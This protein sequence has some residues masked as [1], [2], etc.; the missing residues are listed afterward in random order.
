MSR[1]N[2]AVDAELAEDLSAQAVAQ[3]KTLFGLT[4][5]VVQNALRVLHDGGAAAEIYPS[6][7][8]LRIS[9]EVAGVPL[10]PR[11]V[12]EELVQHLYA[13][14]K[15]WLLRVWY[16]K[17]QRLGEHLRMFYANP[18]ELATAIEELRT[19]LPLQRV[20]FRRGASA[21]DRRSRVVVR[22]V[23]DLSQQLSECAERFVVGVLFSYS[24]RPEES[25]ITQGIIEITAVHESGSPETARAP[26]TSP[27]D[28]SDTSGGPST[29]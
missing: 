8:V 9:R 22:L 26:E 21:E 3:K 7:K 27:Q 10:L 1:T 4:N 5:E 19:V 2:V 24:F 18:D 14:D 6:W 20:E 15:D 12:L 13:T 25:R 29:P 11:N 17:G 16:E 23:A 28:V